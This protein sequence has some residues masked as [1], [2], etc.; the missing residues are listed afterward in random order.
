MTVPID[1]ESDV[2]EARSYLPYRLLKP[3]KYDAKQEYP[4]VMFLHGAGERGSDNKAQLNNGVAEFFSN[5]IT[6]ASYP[7]FAVLPQCPTEVSWSTYGDED[8]EGL[9]GPSA[10]AIEIVLALCDEFNIDQM[11][12]YIGGLSMGAFGTWEIIS[13]YPDLFA[14]AFPICGGG[15]PKRAKWLKKIPIWT[16]HGAKDEVVI[17]DFTRDMIEALERQGATPKYTEYADVGHDSWVKAFKEPEL[18]KWLFAQKKS[19]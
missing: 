14:A 19:E 13:H 12:L 1:V 4:L 2:Y 7:C 6:R 9:S 10:V 3:E 5:S 15:N 16:F 11:R 8:A 18:L 17:P